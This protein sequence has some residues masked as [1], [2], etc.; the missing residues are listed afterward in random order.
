MVRSELSDDR[1]QLMSRDATDRGKRPRDVGDDRFS[2]LGFRSRGK[3]AEGLAVV[4]GLE[5]EP[6]AVGANPKR[7]LQRCR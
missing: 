2:D 3:Q 5:D 7:A 6:V 4:N 1:L